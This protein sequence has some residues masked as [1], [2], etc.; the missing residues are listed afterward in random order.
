MGAAYQI[1]QNKIKVMNTTITIQGNELTSFQLQVKER[2][3]RLMNQFLVGYFLLG[4]LFAS[5]YGTW[6]IAFGVGGTCLA[7]YYSVKMALPDSNLYQYVLAAIYGVF[8]AQF[9]YQMHG[10]FE[11]HFFGFIG[12]AVLV[13]FQKWKL[14]IPLFIVVVIHHSVFSYIQNSGVPEVYFT[15]LNYFDLQTFIIHMLLTAAIFLICGLWS[16][17]LKKYNEIQ[18]IQTI[19]MAELQK[20]AE[21]SIE[22]RRKEEALEERNTILESIGDGFFA[23]DK[24]WTVTYWNQ[25]AEKLLGKLKSEIIG[26][27]LWEV[28]PHA[29]GKTAYN[30]Y[31]K[32]LDENEPQHIEDYFPATNVWYEMNVYPAA[33]GLSI[34]FRDV[35]ERKLS[36]IKLNQLNQS[37]QQQSNELAISN[38]ELEQFAYIA[39]HDLQEPLRMVT[40]FMTQLEN[41]YSA[42]ID[43]KGRQYIHFAI[44]GGKRMRQI[45]LDLLEFSRVGKT[46]DKLEK[47]NL[48]RILDEITGLYRKQIEEK[49]AVI[50]IDR[51]PTLLTFKAPVRQVFQNLVGNSLKYQKAGNIPVIHISANETE[52]DWQFTVKDNGIGIDAAYFDKIFIIFKRLHNKDE[53]PGTGMGLA[54]TKKI[55]E[56]LGG[57]IWVESE[58]GKGSTFHFTVLKNKNNA[59]L[60]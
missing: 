6:L 4:L 45:I 23:T 43:D 58:E 30:A 41:K 21:I 22:R 27:N 52:G 53:Y 39:S 5:F 16:Y 38:A 51:L 47:V 17:H 48:Q 26:R 14:Q 46:E 8:M 25:M 34:Y 40:S 42:V 7:A 2:S 20:E 13:T 33:G 24:D 15:Q 29:V 57:K 28:Y 50:K 32:A 54:V 36:E 1:V 10:M 9:I 49:N 11:M 18:I 60:S 35:T 55:I 31:Q 12:S 19:K 44:D 3:D 59:P 56:N 37:L